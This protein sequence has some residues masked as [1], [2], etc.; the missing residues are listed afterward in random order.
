MPVRSRTA[1]AAPKIRAAFRWLPKVGQAGK[2]LQQVGDEQVGSCLRRTGQRVF[3]IAFGPAGLVF[4]QG[5]ARSS[6][7]RLNPEP[8]HRGRNFF[9]DESARGLQIATGPAR[10]HA[11]LVQNHTG[12]TKAFAA[13]IAPPVLLDPFSHV[14]TSA[15]YRNG[16]PTDPR[17]AE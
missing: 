16:E 8:A 4:R 15:P 6:H 7:Q 5:H 1:C 14:V 11:V 3:E 10:Q 2:A 12:L 17:N 13:D 9:L